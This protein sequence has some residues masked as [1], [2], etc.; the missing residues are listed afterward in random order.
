MS[1]IYVVKMKPKSIHLGEKIVSFAEY[2][3]FVESQKVLHD[4]R[5]RAADILKDAQHAYEEEKKRGYQDGIEAS[6]AYQGE[7]M[8]DVATATVDY[9]AS[10]EGKVTDIV[11]ATVRK[12][13]GN[14]DKTELALG[15]IRLALGK[16]SNESK[17]VLRIPFEQ[18]DEINQKLV[19]LKVEMSD[20]GYLEVVT[21]EQMKIG[22]CRV[23]TEMGSVDSSIE[24][25]MQLLEKTLK[26]RFK[27]AS[28]DDKKMQA[29]RVDT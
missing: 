6:K 2:A 24:S 26:K 12:I 11:L 5:Q 9:L 4:A 20:I 15:L 8:I 22:T 28:I 19:Q 27:P 25:H 14:L 16:V 29:I 23:E 10:I 7:K 18:A 13:I 1:K 17:V 21:D 3:D